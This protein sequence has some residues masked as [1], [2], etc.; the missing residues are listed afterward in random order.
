[1]EFPLLLDD[2]KYIIKLEEATYCIVINE[3]KSRSDNQ[4]P[5]N[6]L[7]L[8]IFGRKYKKYVKD[9]HSYL[10]K[11]QPKRAGDQFLVN[12]TKEYSDYGYTE[13]IQKRY[14]KSIFMNKEQK[15]ELIKYINK[16]K[17]NS[18]IFVKRG[19]N[20]KTGILLYG[21]PGTG[22]TSIARAIAAELNAKLISIDMN[23]IIDVNLTNI[24]RSNQSYTVVVLLEDIDC[25]VGHRD[26]DKMTDSEKSALNKTLQML[27]GVNSANNVIYV[28][29]T[30]HFDQLDP[31][32]TRAGRFDI[33]MEIGQLDRDLAIEMC[34]S[35]KVDS[36]ILSKDTTSIN[37]SKLQNMII[38]HL[39]EI[40]NI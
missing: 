29:T 31:A 2:S 9:L 3:Y 32:L 28:A 4:E 36:S 38:K 20:H 11:H 35:F 16:W 25:I 23:I 15:E 13:F 14:F 17:I 30:N 39:L 8:F 26:T 18:E 7:S 10:S 34:K 6:L 21:E 33:Q 22:K 24:F 40:S 19:I 37:P 5:I 12:V 27:D 1:M